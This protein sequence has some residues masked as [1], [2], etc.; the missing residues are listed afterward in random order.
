LTLGEIATKARHLANANISNYPD[1][2]LL[3]DI[4]LWYQKVV[5]MILESQDDDD[6]DDKR[7]T[8]YP[9]KSIALVAGQRDYP[10]PVAEKMLKLKRIDISYDGV[11]FYRAI[12]IDDGEMQSGMGRSID[13]TQESTLDNLF[14]KTAPRYDTKYN[15]IFIYPRADNSDVSNGAVMRAEWS[16]QV[17]PFTTADYT[18]V[19]TDSTVV[20]GFD[21]PFHPILAYGPAFEYTEAFN[22]PQAGNIKAMLADYEA[23]LK[24]SYSNKDRDRQYVIGGAIPSYGAK[25]NNYWSVNDYFKP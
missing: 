21:D 23:R 13:S 22:K 3:I 7:N 5:T 1:A 24:Q 12:P 18:S 25:G 16:R 15:S 17:T 2:N 9:I 19:I 6:F 10:I 4:N 8:T 11:N 20:P 14:P